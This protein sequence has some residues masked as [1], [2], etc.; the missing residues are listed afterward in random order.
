M[1]N[2]W[3]ELTLISHSDDEA[4][5]IETALEMA[6]AVAI[7][8]QA[9]DD[10][11]IFEPPIGTTPFWAET[12][13]TGLFPQESDPQ[14]IL[15]QLEQSLGEGYTISEHLLN[16]SDWVRAWLDHFQPIRFGENFWVAATEHVI[17]D[18]E[19]I[20]LRLDPGLAF[21][22]GT[23]P[24]TAMCLNWIVSQP[25]LAE[26]T[27]YDYGCGS[28]ILGIAAALCGAKHVWQTDIDPQAL[29]ASRENALK[30]KV[31]RKITVCAAPEE[32]PHVDLLIA[33]ILLEPL[34]FLRDAFEKHL[35]TDTTMIFAGLLERQESDIR[36]RYGDAYTIERAD[37]RDG[38]ILL[39][40]QPKA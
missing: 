22:T 36:A 7:T 17:D 26:K 18:P 6:G 14:A 27:V 5:L 40:L 15:A 23:H 28:G 24:S 10:S 37:Q 13:V 32:A 19:A 25:S 4:L 38:W 35:R 20:V 9:A 16:D 30:N 21:G 33:N 2:A 39:H 11:E 34:C 1:S 12:G 3:L 8:Y 29:T 31:D